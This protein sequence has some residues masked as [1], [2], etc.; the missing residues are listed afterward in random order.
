MFELEL[1][2]NGTRDLTGLTFHKWKV[3]EFKEYHRKNNKGNKK[4]TWSCQ[5]MRCGSEDF[6]FA[7]QLL[8]GVNP[9]CAFCN[10]Q[11][12]GLVSIYKNNARLRELPFDLTGVEAFEL[13]KGNCFY[14]ERKPYQVYKSGSNE[15]VYNGIDR[16]DNTQGYTKDNCVSCCGVC[17]RM[18]GTM[19]EDELR[20]HITLISNSEWYTKR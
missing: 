17:N 14:C 4:A 1:Y 19:T 2:K 10:G 18:K 5:C 15:F 6:L 7:D 20:S 11:Y 12:N 9:R 8:L 16:V 3:L 13:F